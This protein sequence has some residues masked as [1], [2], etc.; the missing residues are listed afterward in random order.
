MVRVAA[1]RLSIAACFLLLV[2]SMGSDQIRALDSH[3][4]SQDAVWQIVA[5]R[6]SSAQVRTDLAGPFTL[7]RFSK[8]AFDTLR[9]GAA[10]DRGGAFIVS[11]PMP[12]GSFG[13]FRATTSSILSARVSSEFPDIQT[14]RADGIDDPAATARF[15]WTQLGF[16]AIV[17]TEQ[18][19][20]YID[21]NEPG[22]NELH[23]IFRKADHRHQGDAVRCLVGMGMDSAEL[24]TPLRANNEF[25]ISHGTTLRTYRLALAATAEYT[26]VAGGT[27]GQAM[28]RM[29]ATIN[30]VNGVYERELSVRLVLVT[31]SELI[32]TNSTT[33]P[34]TNNTPSTM[35]AENQ[36]YLDNNVGTA[37]Y[38]IGHVFSTGG[39][40]VAT[41]QSVC[42]TGSKARGVT[43][44][45]NPTGDVFDIDY[46]SHEIG[47]QF[48][49]NH[50]FNAATAAA[51]GRLHMHTKSA[52]ARPSSR[53]RASAARRTCC[54]TPTIIF[55][56]RVSMR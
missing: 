40:G 29:V 26:A 38:D 27:T 31:G 22:N 53:T 43:G 14:F 41:L 50:T 10:R 25:P 11:L 16:H 35:L 33:D 12:D 8:T 55:M 28:S 3:G 30:R 44:L 52:A 49:G 45:S 6:P 51:T 42:R 32:F 7:A 17:L 15:G 19:T 48:G 13:R 5:E 9:S 20:S 47:H 18:G 24:L 23:V 56:S 36:T 54:T 39:G 37:A 4:A 46:V 34:Y 2:L 1:R 21:P